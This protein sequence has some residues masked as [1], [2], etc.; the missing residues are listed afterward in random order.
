MKPLKTM[1]NITPWRPLDETT[2]RSEPPTP[3]VTISPWTT[4]GTDDVEKTPPTIEDIYDVPKPAASAVESLPE[5]PETP[6]FPKIPEVPALP[7]V[8]EVLSSQVPEYVG[9]RPLDM[10]KF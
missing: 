7:K 6:E 5:I 3:K 4:M 2:L 10:T 8:P 1:R 9:S